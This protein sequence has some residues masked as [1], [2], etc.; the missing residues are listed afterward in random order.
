MPHCGGTKPPA[1]SSSRCRQERSKTFPARLWDKKAPA[2]VTSVCRPGHAPE[3]YSFVDK[4]SIVAIALIVVIG[5]GGFYYMHVSYEKR[6][7]EA[8]KMVNAAQA[9]A[10]LAQDALKQQAGPQ[11]QRADAGPKSKDI[12]AK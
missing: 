1:H 7:A 10:R 6:L 4:R 3:Y 11:V 8:Q 9:A 5:G 12:A 2:G